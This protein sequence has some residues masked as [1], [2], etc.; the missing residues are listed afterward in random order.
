MEQDS[1]LREKE[2]DQL[3]SMIGQIIWFA[4]QSRPDVMFD[5]DGGTQGGHLIILMGKM[6]RSHLLLGSQRESRGLFTVH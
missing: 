4:R 3:T 5:G 2:K 1:P 6:E